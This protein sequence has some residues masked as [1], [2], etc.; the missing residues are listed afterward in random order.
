MGLVC[1][2]KVGGGGLPLFTNENEA[3]ETV[4]CPL[5]SATYR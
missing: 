1:N 4:H 5:L 3:S 2:Y